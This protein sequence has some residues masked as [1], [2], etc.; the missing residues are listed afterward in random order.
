LIRVTFLGTAASRPTVNRNVS[1][2]CVQRE[3]DLMLFDCG[4]G[5]QRQ[6]MRYGSGFALDA[7]FISH[8]HA[9]HYL[10]IVGLLRTMALQGRTDPIE[11]YG[12]PGSDPTLRTAVH[13]GA[14]RI[15]FP[16]TIDERAPGDRIRREEYDVV[17]FEVTHGTAGVG[18]ALIEHDRP[19]R[20]DIERARALG[21]PE[22]PLFGRLHGGRSVE[23]DGRT[24]RPEEVV[25]EPRPG[26][27]VVYTGDTRPSS[28]VRRAAVDADLLIHDCT[29]SDEE[30]VRARETFHATASQ[31]A[32]LAR[33]ARAH[34]LALTH[35]SA[36][37]SETP[38][39]LEREARA[40]FRE[41]VVAY[42]GLVVE[43]PYRRDGDDGD[44]DRHEA[45][46]APAADG[47][48]ER[49]MRHTREEGETRG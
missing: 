35:L 42:D 7:I 14:D 17:P 32:K 48:V 45:G 31:A 19:G 18:W 36:R 12:P 10:G 3:G 25:G 44:V 49:G 27:R 1:S 22:G 47:S 11:I 24:I 39:V 4:E 41:A 13:L 9:D 2:V 33:E 43:I 40:I 29:F 23:V 38:A 34:R 15:G 30:T 26:R 28:V 37:Y 8:V 16:V 6:M 5:T 20:V 46:V 21:I